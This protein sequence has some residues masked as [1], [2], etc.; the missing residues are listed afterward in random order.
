MGKTIVFDLETTEIP[1]TGIKDIE[2]I[3]CLAATCIETQEKYFAD[4]TTGYATILTVMQNAK[5]LV[6]HN[7]IGFDLPVLMNFFTDFNFEGEVFD[8]LVMARALWNDV[9]V[10]DFGRVKAGRLPA[11]LKGRHSLEA[12]GYRLRILKGEYGKQENAWET[13]TTEMAEYCIQDVEVTAALYERELKACGSEQMSKLENEF[14][15][16]MQVQM[17]KGVHFNEKEAINL[18]IQLRIEKDKIY[19][20]LKDLFPERVISP[21]FGKTCISK[22]NSPKRHIS[23]DSSY[24]KIA[25]QEFNPNSRQQIGERLMEK[26][27]WSPDDYTEKGTVQIN[28]TIL[29]GMDYPEAKLLSRGMMLAKRLA[30]LSD[31]AQGWMKKLKGDRIHGRI[32]TGGAISG[33]CTHSGPNLAQVPSNNS[34]FG[35]ECRALFNV[36]KGYKMVGCDASGLELRCLAHYLARFDNGAYAD[37]VLNG[38]IH[39][40]NMKAAGLPERNM[41]KTFI[42]GWLYGAGAEKLGSIVGGGAKEGSKLQNKFMKSFPAVKK[43]KEAV[44]SRVEQ[45]GHLKGLDGRK[46]RTRSPHSA[47]NLLL[48][49]AGALVMKQWANLVMAEIKKSGIDATPV[50]NI[51]DEGQFEVREDQA[52]E[53]AKICEDCM[54][55]AGDAFGFRIPIAGE[56]K[57][58]DN[59]SQTH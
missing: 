22:V 9:V 26:Y 20:D 52:E 13:Y 48:Q 25:Y 42:Y 29:D 4:A 16:G 35:G 28:E 14:A 31:G 17:D 50:L 34:P 40:A 43:L 49:S 39:T 3:H 15:Q 54:P 18:M 59:W 24:C 1:K 5:T 56:A 19:E 6:G 57:I 10:K 58:G 2:K 12:Y 46:L 27:D 53:F 47:L 30:Q 36:S 21:D 7:I 51:H 23:K 38:D 44:I 45:T 8:T 37:I 11:R 32:N 33:R 55:L 41:A